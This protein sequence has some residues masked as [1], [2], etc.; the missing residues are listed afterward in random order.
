MAIEI[1][2]K[3]YRNIQEQVKENQDNIAELERIIEDSGLS[4][5]KMVSINPNDSY[6][7]V[8]SL[9]EQGYELIYFKYNNRTYISTEIEQDQ[10]IVF[11]CMNIV[12][13]T[14]RQ[15]YRKL[16]T[17][18]TWTQ[19]YYNVE[20]TSNK[21]TTI[22]SESTDT[23]YPSAKAVYDAK[24]WVEVTYGTTTYDEIT[25]IV[26]T[27]NKMPYVKYNE[28]CYL[29]SYTYNNRHYFSTID[30]P[31]GRMTYCYVT[32]SDSWAV[33]QV[34]V[35]NSSQKVNSITPS[36]NSNYY[37]SVQA[38]KGLLTPSQ[39]TSNVVSGGEAVFTF[40]DNVFDSTN[41]KWLAIFTMG[42]TFTM[43]PLYGLAQNTMY[44][45]P[46]SFVYDSGGSVVTTTLNYKITSNKMIQVWSGNSS[47]TLANGYTAYLSLIR[48]F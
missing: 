31:N 30:A 33:A 5:L 34:N 47:F 25:T 16:N 26:E 32:S 39:A 38:A 1:N 15:Y 48:L 12:G 43:F 41:N 4:G 40:T 27:N 6:D 8:S 45:C 46:G 3:V 23:Q 36:T 29:Y 17:D 13:T 9:I 35:Q 42:N 7:H 37:P 19:S 10:A 2:G 20:K 44:K 14:V 22:T 18:G 24:D 11:T 21:T 28:R